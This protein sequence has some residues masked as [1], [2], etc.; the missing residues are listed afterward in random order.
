MNFI[1]SRKSH[2]VIWNNLLFCRREVEPPKYVAFHIISSMALAGDTSKI[3]NF[4]LGINVIFAVPFFWIKKLVT[5]L[6]STGKT[7]FITFIPPYSTYRIH[8]SS[9]LLRQ[10]CEFGVLQYTCITAVE[11]MRIEK[12]FATKILILLVTTKL[13]FLLDYLVQIHILLRFGDKK[14]KTEAQKYKFW[15]IYE[16]PKFGF[17][18]GR[19]FE[20]V[21]S[22]LSR[23]L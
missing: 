8:K 5:S 15:V 11:L 1:F 2:Y 10:M 18:P 21:E 19:S 23:V 3:A 13:L 14:R 4:D 22:S 20:I 6:K 12:S 16:G 9:Y 7:L 17:R